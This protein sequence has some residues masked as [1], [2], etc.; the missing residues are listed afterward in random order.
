[1]TKLRKEQFKDI[2]QTLHPVGSIYFS[3]LST[4]PATLLGFGTWTAWAAGKT[5]VGVDSGDANLDAAEDTYGAKT[6]TLV[7]ANLPT[8]LHT[9]NPPSTESSDQS[10]THNHTQ[11]YRSSSGNSG[12]GGTKWG[13]TSSQTSGNNSVS[14]THTLDIA[15]FNSGSYGGDGA[16]NNIQPSIVAYMWKRTA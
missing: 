13:N 14:H 9:V 8:H 15:E 7:E 6:V 11:S 5:P 10:V 3:T 1:M 12:S 2:L 16:H 4:N